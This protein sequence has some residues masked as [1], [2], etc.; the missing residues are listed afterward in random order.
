MGQ[1]KRRGSFETRQR[2]AAIRDAEAQLRRDEQR[3]LTT[4]SKQRGTRVSPLLA[5]LAATFGVTPL[6]M[7]RY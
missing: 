1:A 2:K 6:A 4:R 5:I 3:E 7:R